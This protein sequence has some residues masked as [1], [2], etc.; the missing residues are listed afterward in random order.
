MSLTSVYFGKTFWLIEPSSVEKTLNVMCNLKGFLKLKH[1]ECCMSMTQENCKC[2]EGTCRLLARG[3]VLP[4][5]G[6][7]GMCGPKGYGFSA[8]LGINWVLILAILPPF[9][10]YTGYRFLHFSLQFG[11]SFRRSYFFITPSFT[12]SR[13]VFFYPV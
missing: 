2:L 9:W 12:H 1:C 8:I 13:F 3:G 4:Y 7:I 6:Y 5:M 10:S 11:F